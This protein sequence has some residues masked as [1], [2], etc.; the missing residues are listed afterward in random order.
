MEEMT[1]EVQ[2]ILRGRV[3]ATPDFQLK[4][5]IGVSSSNL[6][7]GANGVEPLSKQGAFKQAETIDF[8]QA[9]TGA[10]N[11]E[12]DPI[13]E[14]LELPVI[15]EE[16]NDGIKT[17]VIPEIISEPQVETTKPSFL[18][19][20]QMPQNQSKPTETYEKPTEE[21]KSFIDIQMPTMPDTILGGE[22]VGDQDEMFEKTADDSVETTK[23]VFPNFNIPVLE[24]NDT[25]TDT[26]PTEE[27][28]I[29]QTGNEQG[30]FLGIPLV[31]IMSE[32]EKPEFPT[33]L[34]ENNVENNNTER[35]ESNQQENGNASLE[36]IKATLDSYI[37]NN[38]KIINGLFEALITAHEELK[39]ANEM[40]IELSKKIDQMTGNRQMNNSSA[41]PTNLDNQ[42]VQAPAFLLQR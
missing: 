20:F 5:V 30:D 28:P 38:E 23:P 16:T 2:N 7:P 39:K 11:A 15:G 41:F 9:L 33:S 37:K 8:T 12:T 21:E 29:E 19:S 18:D 26:I 17:P 40:Q 31:P 6:L 24:N 34:P 22:P 36:E 14:T 10:N 13:E 27:K 1:S 42:N 32:P 35:E 3:N 4:K 25:M